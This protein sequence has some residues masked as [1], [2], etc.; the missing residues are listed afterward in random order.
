MLVLDAA[1]ASPP[2]EDDAITTEAEPETS[3]LEA[4]KSSSII[5]GSSI[6]M[7]LIRMVR[8]KV[9]ALLL[10]PAGVGLEAVFDSIVVLAKTLFDAGLGTSGVREVAVAAASGSDVSVA[11]TVFTLRRVCLVLGLIGGAT[12]FL[13]AD[14]ISTVA[15]GTTPIREASGCC[16]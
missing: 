15:L 12:V 7:M 8:T 16:R 11:R 5:G 6:V 10:G 3:H 9:V 1:V 2:L 4:L 13:G 14:A